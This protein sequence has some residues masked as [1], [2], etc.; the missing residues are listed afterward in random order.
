MN[1][2][3]RI[4]L[5]NDNEEVLLVLEGGSRVDKEDGDFFIKRSGWGL[6]GG[7]KKADESPYQAAC[8]ELL[9]ETGLFA[10]INRE[11]AKIVS[12]REHEVLLFEARRPVGQIQTNDP[13]IRAVRWVKWRLAYDSITFGDSSF[14]I[15]KS[16]MPHIH[17]SP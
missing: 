8:R 17:H 4:R 11:P 1:I 12:G 2:T 13:Y 10:D 7:R 9:E 15:Y 3:V 16:H 14:P 6:P 5:M